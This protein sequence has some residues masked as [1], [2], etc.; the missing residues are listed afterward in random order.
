MLATPFGTSAR[1]G[2]STLLLLLILTPV[3]HAERL[4]IKIY[5]TADGL[6]SNEVNKIVRD[7]RGFLW[8]CTG[9]G[10]SRFDGYAFTNFG[11]DQGLPHHN[12][13]DLL[14]TR[15]GEYWI[16]TYGGLVRFSP[17]ANRNVLKAKDS[18]GSDQMFTV[19]VPDDDDRAARA[20]LVLFEDR[21]GV[22]WCGTRKGL[23]RLDRRE[24][25]FALQPVEIRMPHDYREET[26]VSDM[27]QD[28]GGT[29]WIAS[30]SGLYQHQAGGD[31]KRFTARDGLPDQYLQDLLVDRDGQLWVGTRSAG[32]FRF[33]PGETTRDPPRITFSLTARDGL[34]SGWISQVFQTSNGKFW[35]ATSDG[36]IEFF[37]EGNGIGQKFHAYSEK[38]GLS[39]HEVTAL[40]EDAAG[41]L[42]LGSNA[43]AMKVARAGFIT[44]G[45]Q[46]GIALVNAIFGDQRGAVCFRGYVIG[47]GH[48]SVFEGLKAG[49]VHPSLGKPV[50]RLGC[51]DGQEFNWSLPNEL[52]RYEGLGWVGEQVT[53]QSR[54]GE[55]WIG[56]GYGLFR[57]P[58]AP[59]LKDLKSARPVLYATKD[60]LAANQIYRVFEDSHENIWIAT[61]SSPTNGL[62]IWERN[63]QKLRDLS[64]SPGLPSVKD[65]VPRS[66]GEDRSGTIWI[67]IGNG[68]A[69]YRNGR[70]DSLTVKEGLPT[71][72]I[73]SI[74]TDRRGRLWLASSVGGL[75]RIDDPTADRP[76]FKSYTTSDGLSSNSTRVLAEDLR[77]E[78]YV[79]T[80]RGLDEVDPETGRI[81]HFTT[82][83]GLAAGEFLSA[84]CD[85][86]GTLWFGTL[87]GLSR[88]TPPPIDTAVA[89]P[90]ILLT[91]LR[92]AGSAIA[93]SAIGDEKMALA[94]LPASQN[95]LQIEFTSLNFAAGEVLRYQYKLDGTA[96]DWS[97]PVDVRSVTFA[98]LAPGQYKFLVRAVN[99][100]GVYSSTPASITF[101]ILHPLWQR[102]WFIMLVAAI[103]GLAAYSLY[104]YRMARLLEVERVRTRIA[105]DLHDDIGAGL[106]RVAI[107]TEVVKQ[108]VAGKAEESL[109]L[110]TEI[111]DSSRNLVGSMR[112]IVWAIGP[113]Q[114]ELVEVV[115]RVRQFASDVLEAKG[116]KW[117]FL[118]PAELERIKL[119]PE[120]RRHLFLT[121][122]EAINNSARYAACHNMRLSLATTD[123]QLVGEIFDDGCGFE[124]SPLR[125]S[126]TR[127]HGMANMQ[128]RSTEIGGSLKISS[129]PGQGTRIRLMIPLGKR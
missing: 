120:Q 104:R 23:F 51:F 106:S 12:V 101:R 56:T 74:H 21:D 73:E 55:W 117:D 128:R 105:T 7:S 8:F 42:W 94:D 59:T 83:D 72:G 31:W 70:F 26:Y 129:T 43:G 107:L 50:M 126:G 103:A 37:P 127:G 77:G 13:T 100:D 29:L 34:P 118:L 3:T 65:N 24:G 110:L 46:D 109:P 48:R 6:P 62:A 88:F 116:I 76:A 17:N 66:F 60:G 36:L 125:M 81:K 82:A 40:S 115:M 78:I 54:S 14:E 4:P 84:Y 57:F 71:G 111:A 112:D 92:V 16:G 15:G 121:F 114:N 52:Q 102:W 91:G 44:F 19:V 35:A 18:V 98:N 99:S 64:G 10:L 32:L 45:E 90:P 11:T 47:D 38:N 20:V 85:Q 27:V 97:A 119:S 68:L 25:H 2:M 124:D 96:A 86:S 41:N 80:G 30:P 122:K 108:Q 79:S 39:Y 1:V 87:K 123:H 28:R 75:V 69:R 93:V 58:T 22:I 33:A 53:L 49:R 61:T 113:E 5:A 67:G 63:S 95:Q 9:D 89:A